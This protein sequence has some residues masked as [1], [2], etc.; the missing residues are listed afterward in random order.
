MSRARTLRG[1]ANRRG[2]VDDRELAAIRRWLD[3]DW[4]SHD[5]DMDAIRLIRR[6]VDELEGRDR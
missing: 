5:V 6:L 3:D 2:R 4:E 1:L